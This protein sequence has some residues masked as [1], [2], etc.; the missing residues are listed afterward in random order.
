MYSIYTNKSNNINTRLTLCLLGSGQRHTTGRYWYKASPKDF[1]KIDTGA[2]NAVLYQ[3][4]ALMDHALAIMFNRNCDSTQRHCLRRRL[5]MHTSISARKRLSSNARQMVI[6]C[7]R[8]CESQ[9]TGLLCWPWIRPWT[10]LLA[11]R[12]SVVPLQD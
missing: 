3:G 10:R 12:S 4:R 11:N 2:Y 1:R 5:R 8:Q 6:S 9:P 7:A